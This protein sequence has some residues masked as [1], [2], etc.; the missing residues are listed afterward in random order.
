[1]RVENNRL[2]I[3]DSSSSEKH[4][5]F[6]VMPRQFD[7][8]NIFYGKAV[9]MVLIIFAFVVLA[10]GIIVALWLVDIQSVMT[11][12]TAVLVGQQV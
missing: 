12:V 5:N 3:G 2:N 6:V 8:E 4:Q 9:I 11:S 1:M 10:P 7:L